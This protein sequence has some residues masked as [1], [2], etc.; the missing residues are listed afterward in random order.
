MARENASFQVGKFSC[1]GAKTSNTFA[2]DT[3]NTM[4]ELT[5]LW[6]ICLLIQSLI[7]INIVI[8]TN[9]SLYKVC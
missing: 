2:I 6:N 7:A 3:M 1:V 4:P 8:T 5:Q 9:H